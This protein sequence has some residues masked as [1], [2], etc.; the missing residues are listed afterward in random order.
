MYTDLFIERNELKDYKDG[1]KVVAVFKEWEEKRDS[2]SATIIKSLG[3]PG[4][5]ET[6]IH[7]ILHD[8]GLPYE[9][10]KEIEDA[11]DKINKDLDTK[12]IKKRRD[13]RDVLTFTIDPITAKDFDDALSFKVLSNGVYEVGIHIADVSYYVEPNTLLDQEAYDRAT[14]VYLVDRVVPMLPEVL[15]NGLCS[16]RPKEDKFTFSAVFTLNKE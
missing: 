8:Y 13:F 1:E 14:S 9:F 16:L 7:A 4:E 11:A 5:K 10:P 6:E 2:P 3:L 15:S 12:E